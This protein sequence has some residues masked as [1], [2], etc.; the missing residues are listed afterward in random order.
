[1]IV[2]PGEVAI[3]AI[4]F[5]TTSATIRSLVMMR[6]RARDHRTELGEPNVNERLYGIE[7]AVLAMAVDIDRMAEAQ[8]YTTRQ[9]SERFPYPLDA[10]PAAQGGRS[11]RR[12]S[13]QYG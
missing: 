12:F 4:V 8:R 5:G 1:M 3:V 11:C 6:M 10:M 13:G 2:D 7:P 9:L